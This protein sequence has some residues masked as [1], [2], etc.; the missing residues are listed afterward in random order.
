MPNALTHFYIFEKAIKKT[1]TDYGN[2]QALLGRFLDYLDTGM[3][4][5]ADDEQR[6]LRYYIRQVSSKSSELQGLVRKEFEKGTFGY[7]TLAS[8]GYL[9]SNGPDMF[10]VPPRMDRT[11]LETNKLSRLCHYNTTGAPVI[12]G[13]TQLKD[14][15]NPEPGGKEGERWMYKLAYWLGHITHIAA[16]IT[17]HPFVNSRAGAL[18]LLDK[19]FY[20]NFSKPGLGLK[21]PWSLH[22]IVEQYQDRY[23]LGEF[24]SPAVKWREVDFACLAAY[25]LR[26]NKKHLFIGETIDDFY[27]QGYGKKQYFAWNGDKYETCRAWYWLDSATKSHMSFRNYFIN[28]MATADQLREAVTEVVGPEDFRA[29]IDQAAVLAV[30]M[31]KEAIDFLLGDS[32][33]V[34][35]TPRQKV[36]SV[37]DQFRLLNLHWNIDT[38]HGFKFHP[39]DRD[40]GVGENI[41]RECRVPVRIEL[42]TDKC[43]DEDPPG[44]PYGPSPPVR[45][46][47]H[48]KS[49]ELARVQPTYKF[50]GVDVITEV[51]KRN[52]RTADFEVFAVLHD[53][54]DPEDVG[55]SIRKKKH[56]ALD[57]KQML[58]VSKKELPGGAGIKRS[59]VLALSL[60]SGT[61][62]S[63]PAVKS[64]CDKMLI[65]T[66]CA[67]K[68]WERSGSGRFEKSHVKESATARPSEQ[69]F[70]KFYFFRKQDDGAYQCWPNKSKSRRWPRSAKDVTPGTPQDVPLEPGVHNIAVVLDKRNE[71]EGVYL[72]LQTVWETEKAEEAEDE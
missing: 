55:E 8:Y 62:S 45:A 1:L 18:K 57:L 24:F 21:T 65:P 27:G 19:K 49:G 51:L 33:A 38:G 28:V 30:K 39:C 67:S 69:L 56:K 14:Q 61:E 11:G 13:L 26:M 35:A 22:N 12:Y 42:K 32:N 63:D 44:W 43:I 23:V 17:V 40:A 10:F 46:V 29:H 52:G 58:S 34:G 20:N 70:M 6:C 60:A 15:M 54:T 50:W 41:V 25:H 3:A 4:A 59:S 72:D 9:G 53:E 7:A 71:L 36:Y 31:L 66:V 48:H 47:A 16:D 5:A 2:Q 37:R 64:L 68:V